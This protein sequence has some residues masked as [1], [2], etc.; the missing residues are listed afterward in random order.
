[1]LRGELQGHVRA[2]PHVQRPP[3]RA[4]EAWRDP[5]QVHLALQPGAQQDPQRHGRAGHLGFP[6]WRHGCADAREARHPRQ[7]HLRRQAVR[8]GGQVR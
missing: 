3:R 8:S 1:M 7:H 5:P 4:P 2:R 6:G